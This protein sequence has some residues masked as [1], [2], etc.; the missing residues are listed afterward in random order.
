METR[1]STTI[2][3]R[4]MKNE[5]NENFQEAKERSHVGKSKANSLQRNKRVPL[6]NLSNS[7]HPFQTRSKVCKDFSKYVEFSLIEKN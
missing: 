1:R 2:K 6:A 5:N 4:R 7:C 3:N